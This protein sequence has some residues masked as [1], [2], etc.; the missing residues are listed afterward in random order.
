[1]Y[2]GRY[3]RDGPAPSKT[4]Y[5]LLQSQ[6]LKSEHKDRLQDIVNLD[7]E[8]YEHVK[9]SKKILKGEE[10]EDAED[11]LIILMHQRFLA[12]MDTKYVNYEQIDIDE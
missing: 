6:Q 12:G 8:I 1:M 3:F 5:E 4:F 11:E 2:L 9:E 10:L 7:P